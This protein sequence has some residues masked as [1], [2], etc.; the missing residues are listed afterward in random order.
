RGVLN[1]MKSFKR[2]M[3]GT[4]ESFKIPWQ[5]AAYIVIALLVVIALAVINAIVVA[6]TAA[7]K[8]IFETSLGVH[9]ELW[10]LVSALASVISAVAIT[11]GVVLFVAVDCQANDLSLIQKRVIALFSWVGFRLTLLVIILG[12]V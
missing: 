5:S 4:V 8:H 11:F 2:A 7:H 6:E 9:P 1:F 12:S 3:F 10:V